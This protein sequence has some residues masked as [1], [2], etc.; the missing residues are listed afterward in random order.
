M[1]QLIAIRGITDKILVHVKNIFIPSK[2]FD[3]DIEG[4]PDLPVYNISSALS[5]AEVLT[6]LGAEIVEGI[7]LT[8]EKFNTLLADRTRLSEH[9]D[10]LRAHLAK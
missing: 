8:D 1:Y 2:H 4:L 3:M 7:E 10:T 5:E 9:I 6:R